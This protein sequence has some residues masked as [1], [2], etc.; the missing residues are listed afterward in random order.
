MN[1]ITEKK[2]KELRDKGVDVW[3]ISRLNSYN[4][5]AYGYKRTY[6]GEDRSRGKDNIYSFAGSE[7]HDVLEDIYN[8]KA[9]KDDLKQIYEGIITKSKLF[10]IN[11]PNEN[12]ENNWRSDMEHF[13]ANF[14]KLDKK[15]ITEKH[16]LLQVEDDIWVQGY[17][18]ALYKDEDGTLTVL[19]WKTSSKFTGQAL[20]DAGR[21]LLL[22]KLALEQT[23]DYKVS[24]IAWFMLKYV[25]VSY[26]NRK[27]MRSR[28]SWV[29]DTKNPIVKALIK[30]GEEDF[31][32]E[33]MFEEASK[34]NNLNNLPKEVQDQFVLEDCILEYE[35]TDERIDECLSYIKN[36]VKLATTD[37]E[38]SPVEINR[39]T[40]FFCNVLCNHRDTCKYLKMYRGEKVNELDSTVEKE[41]L[42]LFN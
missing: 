4:N 37:K 40:E 10:G 24:K 16:F 26:G 17:I 18:D 14:V 6:V 35:I 19:D 39:G 21:Q 27:S 38:Y 36:T 33:L 8:D 42:K 31:V 30:H 9:N 28:R 34:N 32:A 7:I 5:C 15:M 11:F 25:Y 3:S 22:Y 13:V 20:I 29:K 12:I 2:A 41:L 1:T 23:S